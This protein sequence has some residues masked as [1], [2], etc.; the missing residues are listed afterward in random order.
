LCYALNGT[1]LFP[2]VRAAHIRNLLMVLDH[3]PEWEARMTEEVAHKRYAGRHV[4]IHDAGDFF[5]DD[6]LAAWLRIA[7]ATPGATFYAYTKEVTRFRRMVEGRAPGNFRWVYSLGGTEDHLIDRDTDRHAEVFPDEDAVEAAGY[8]SQEASDLLAVYGPPK[9]GIPANNI[10]HF[11]KRMGSET[12]GSLQETR[13][14][15]RAEKAA[16]RGR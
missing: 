9:V 4:R 12:F 11:R 5:S 13:D 3:L 1:Y 2:K 10:R 14:E 16:A 8:A 7:E 15:A 6:Y